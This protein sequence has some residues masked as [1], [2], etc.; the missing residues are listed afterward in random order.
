LHPAAWWLSDVESGTVDWFAYVDGEDAALEEVS[1]GADGSASALLFAGGQAFE[2]GVGI[3]MFCDDV[4][5]FSGVGFWARGRGGEHI[6]FLAA[7]PATD[8]TEGR[9]DCDPDLVNVTIIRASTWS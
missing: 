5:A 4:S 1:P 9:G 6:R 3:G 8:A 2:S 7:I